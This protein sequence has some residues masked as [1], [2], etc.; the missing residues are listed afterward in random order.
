MNQIPSVPKPNSKRT[1]IRLG[2]TWADLQSAYPGV[3]AGGA[4]GASLAVDNRPWDGI[5]DGVADW[6]LSGVW[7]PDRPNFAPSDAQVTRLLAGDG[8]EPGCC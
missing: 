6:C 2:S 5:F 8:P 3:E 4:E 7:N 1:G